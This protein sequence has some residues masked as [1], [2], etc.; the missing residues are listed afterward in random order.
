MRLW[1]CKFDGKSYYEI[2]GLG[3]KVEGLVWNFRVWYEILGF[4][5]KCEGSG[6]LVW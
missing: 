5:M 1:A 6:I 2:Q 4:G 3:M